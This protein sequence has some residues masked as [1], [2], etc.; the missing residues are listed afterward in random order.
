MKLIMIYLS[1]TD[2]AKLW[3]RGYG[4]LC[5]NFDGTHEVIKLHRVAHAPEL[6]HNLISIGKLD[7]TG[8]IF[9]IGQGMPVMPNSDI[10][11]PKEE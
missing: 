4:D 7:E 5:I 8:R 3:I 9:T 1:A 6:E 11:S 10:C 2:D